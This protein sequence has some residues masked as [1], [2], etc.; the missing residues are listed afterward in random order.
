MSF[1]E[2]LW[3]GLYLLGFIEEPLYVRARKQRR[4]TLMLMRA[5]RGFRL[6]A[7]GDKRRQIQE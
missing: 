6:G 4:H 2:H 3:A 1:N 7:L 5:L